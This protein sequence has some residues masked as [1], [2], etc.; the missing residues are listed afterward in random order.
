VKLDVVIPTYNRSSLLRKTID[1]LLQAPV[2]DGLEVTIVPV[3]NNSTDGTAELIHGLQ[4][5]SKL[6]IRY[7]KALRQGSSSTRNAG[8]HSGT[9][10]IIAF[11]DD[12]ETVDQNYYHAIHREFSDEHTEYIGGPYFADWAAPKP[13]WLPPGFHAVIGVI[14]AKPRAPMNETFPGILMGGNAVL[15]RRVFERVGVYSEKLGRVGR[16]LLSE[17]DA[18]FYSRLLKNQ[19]HGIYVPDL[20]IYHHIPAERLTRRYHRRWCFWRG[21]SQGILD[22]E[23]RE[24]VAYAL[25]VPRYRFSQALKALLRLPR[26]LFLHKRPGDAFADELHSWGLAGF[27]YG[28][29]FTQVGRLHS[30]QPQ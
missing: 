21:V 29:H 10:D 27:L 22:K 15:R 1:S 19:I 23:Q 16:G 6:P 25:G 24:P 8:I 18:E 9:S 12:D 13:D 14:P 7:V 20:I 11:V 4:A 5:Q 3:D 17:E 30:S 28:K 26:D 2:P